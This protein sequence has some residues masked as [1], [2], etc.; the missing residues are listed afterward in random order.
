MGLGVG[1]GWGDVNVLLTYI[2]VGGYVYARKSVLIPWTEN[3]QFNTN[4]NA[5]ISI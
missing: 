3:R 5:D 4:Q 2:C 1:V